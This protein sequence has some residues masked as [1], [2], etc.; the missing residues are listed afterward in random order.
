MNLLSHIHGTSSCFRF[1]LYL[2]TPVYRTHVGITERA[3]LLA[4]IRVHDTIAAVSQSSLVIGA[5]ETVNNTL[6]VVYRTI[7]LK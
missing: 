2:Q 1:F 4:R 3:G 7:P 6:I 5:T